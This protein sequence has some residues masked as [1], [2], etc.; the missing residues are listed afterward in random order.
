MSEQSPT[1][2]AQQWLDDSAST[3]TNHQ[4]TEHFNLVSKKVRITGEK[5]FDTVGYND[6]ARQSEEEFK[7]K[8]LKS[9]SYKG[10]K[11]MATN[12]RQIMFKTVELIIANSGSRK[13]H[14]LEILL[15]VEEGGIW[16]VTQQRILTDDESRHDGLME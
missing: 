1:E 13:M 7:E 6:W 12:E 15:E 11:L 3:A 10:F 4:F 16:R 9:V 5:G 8:V 14:G 2:I